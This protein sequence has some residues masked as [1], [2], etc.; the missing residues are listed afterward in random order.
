VTHVLTDVP[1]FTKHLISAFESMVMLHKGVGLGPDEM[2]AMY[3]AKSE[4]NKFRQRSAY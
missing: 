3:F 1:E 2:T 4:V